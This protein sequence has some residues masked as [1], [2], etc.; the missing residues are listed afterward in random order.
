MKTL[1]K[2]FGTARFKSKNSL[3][4]PIKGKLVTKIELFQLLNYSENIRNPY[5]K[6]LRRLYIHR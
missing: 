4:E 2:V 5:K 6:K 3:D 1:E